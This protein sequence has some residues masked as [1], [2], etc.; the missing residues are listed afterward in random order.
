MLG[1]AGEVEEGLGGVPLGGG[2]TGRR[3]VTDAVEVAVR[4]EVFDAAAEGEKAEVGFETA[5][6]AG[7]GGV[8]GE[9]GAE[10]A[11]GAGELAAQRS[12]R[13]EGRGGG[14]A[15]EEPGKRDFG[16][17]LEPLAEVGGKTAVAR[18]GAVGYVRRSIVEP[19]L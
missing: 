8:V 5:L 12:G 9:E 14:G 13:G 15:G 11:A 3:S 2:D 7:E 10:G 17:Q 18:G 6:E 16:R 19:F 1:E 4:G